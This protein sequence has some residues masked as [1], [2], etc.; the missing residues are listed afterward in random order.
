MVLSGSDA[1]VNI[2]GGMR[3]DDPAADLGIV[4]ALVSSFRNRPLDES[5]VVFGEVGL[6]GE[7][8]GV[9]AAEQRVREAVKWDSRHVLCQRQMQSILRV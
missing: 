2:A 8:R 7:V 6:S 4:F 5:M 9:S 1:Y 3:L